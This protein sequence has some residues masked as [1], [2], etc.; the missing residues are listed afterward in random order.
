M[1]TCTCGQ[2]INAGDKFC[3]RC[4]RPAAAPLPP[5]PR[6]P[7]TC[8]KCGR[9]APE[10]EPFCSGCGATMTGFPV[11][12]EPA[13]V[14]QPREFQWKWALLTIP[15]VV[16]VT[17]VCMMGTVIAFMVVGQPLENDSPKQAVVGTVVLLISMLLGGMAAGWLSP[18]RTIVEP[19]VGIAAALIG[20]NVLI[21]ETG[22]IL[23]GWILPFGIGAGGAQIGEWL[24]R[25]F[26]RSRR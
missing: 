11:L 7:A 13:N 4:G 5:L 8:P 1:A 9:T 14:A 17:V 15:I 25:R 6:L 22:N 16:V 18:G 3:T 10:P 21:G 19:G 26:S 12:R 24:Q 23:L 20:V 2:P